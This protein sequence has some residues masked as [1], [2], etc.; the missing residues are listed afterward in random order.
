MEGDVPVV[1]AV[2]DK[3]LIAAA[4]AACKQSMYAQ[5]LFRLF[6]MLCQSGLYTAGKMTVNY[7]TVIV[8]DDAPCIPCA[9]YSCVYIAVL[10]DAVVEKA[11]SGSRDYRCAFVVV[12]VAAL[13]IGGAEEGVADVKIADPCIFFKNG[14]QEHLPCVRVVK[15]GVIAV[16]CK[17]CAV[18]VPVIEIHRRVYVLRRRIFPA[19][20]VGG[21]VQNQVVA[22][23]HIDLSISMIDRRDEPF[24]IF[25]CAKQII[26]VLILL[27][28]VITF[29]LQDQGCGRLLR[30]VCEKAEYRKAQDAE[31]ARDEVQLFLRESSFSIQCL[32]FFSTTYTCLRKRCMDNKSVS[33]CHTAILQERGK[34][35][36]RENTYF[37]GGNGIV[38]QLDFYGLSRYNM[39]VIKGTKTFC[40][41]ASVIEMVAVM[42][43]KEYGKR[44]CL[45]YI[46]ILFL[47]GVLSCAFSASEMAGIVCDNDG[48]YVN[49]R[50]TSISQNTRHFP[51]EEYLA[52][53]DFGAQ[54][55]MSAARGRSI[56]PVSRSV[57]HVAIQLFADGLRTNTYAAFRHFWRQETA[58][59][60][61][62][63]IIITN[64]IH[65]QDG[66][67]SGS[68]F[69]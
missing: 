54:E 58:S 29:A 20:P 9:Q 24:E 21:V 51:A 17:T 19:F 37:P 62:C 60:C 10:N 30:H 35:F 28:R 4:D 7:F 39:Y 69:S 59:H 23:T 42:F 52:T 36:N 44:F 22:Q 53:R 40:H 47:W 66:Q 50:T 67:K 26:A 25:W 45:F 16:Q 5:T 15:R 11:Q 65:Q 61:L 41:C 32:S 27:W 46:L 14:K 49:Q 6:H 33:Y 57:R 18:E 55:T 12:L 48:S 68:L 31:T 63:G 8:G 2:P 43:Q 3:A 38:T 13:F 64:Y 56:R 34:R 1:N